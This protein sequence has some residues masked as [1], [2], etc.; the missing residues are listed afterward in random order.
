MWHFQSF[1]A[2]SS[3]LLKALRNLSSCDE[4]FTAR[5][6]LSLRR[7]STGDEHSPG[8]TRSRL[9]RTYAPPQSQSPAS[10]YSTLCHHAKVPLHNVI[11]KKL[12][13]FDSNTVSSL[14]KLSICHQALSDADVALLCRSL[15]A[16][17]SLQEISLNH[18]SLSNNASTSVANLVYSTTSLSV[19]ELF[20]ND[21]G[22][23]GMYT[24]SS[25]LCSCSHIKRLKLGDNPITSSGAIILSK[26]LR[27]PQSSLL[28]LHLGGCRIGSEGADALT[29]ALIGNSTLSSLGLRDNYLGVKGILA[30]SPLIAS[31]LCSL[32]DIQ[33]KSNNIDVAG[34][35]HFSRALSSNTSLRVIEVQNNSFGS[36]GAKY[37][38]DALKNNS[39][40]SAINFN[41][42]SINDDG[43]AELASLILHSSTL[44]TLGLANNNITEEGARHLAFALTNNSSVVGV[45]LS[46]NRIKDDGAVA[47]GQMIGHNQTLTS[48]DLSSN[49]IGPDGVVVISKALEINQTLKHL[50]LG[51]NCCRNRGA[52]ALSQALKVNQSLT[53]LCLTD[54]SIYEP[55]GIKLSEGLKFNKTLTTLS[56]GGQGERANRIQSS[57]RRI[58]DKMVSKNSQ[59]NRKHQSN[60]TKSL[61]D[62]VLENRSIRQGYELAYDCGL[63][64]CLDLDIDMVSTCL[65]DEDIVF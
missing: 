3:P 13:A 50:D 55:G 41:Q 62:E 27:T 35:L 36:L 37:I 21:I 31:P 46:C 22:D 63:L 30:I 51:N 53:R 18:C 12:S 1:E 4:E 5:K 60:F 40:V 39:T 6:S 42:C 49:L 15:S 32:M 65:D 45:D 52:I 38:L 44:C 17:S 57:T 47:F 43:V 61:I 11:L 19:V 25:L 9:H 2:P 58:I 8:K 23:A 64:E 24:W 28:Q 29:G 56:F 26:G 16:C 7:A 14:N 20:G 54:N 48:L 34:A 10:I 59:N 33:L